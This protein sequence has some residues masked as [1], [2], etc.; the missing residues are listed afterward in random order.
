M[1]FVGAAVTSGIRIPGVR[2]EIVIKALL[3]VSRA[4]P[5]IKSGC[6]IGQ[7]A[8]PAEDAA[9]CLEAAETSLAST[10]TAR[11]ITIK[12]A[13]AATVKQGGGRRCL[14]GCTDKS[15]ALV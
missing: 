14:G 4:C 15:H 3:C 12:S 6:V 9:V 11:A 7:M 2:D 1:L 10:R 5:V 13:D 8:L